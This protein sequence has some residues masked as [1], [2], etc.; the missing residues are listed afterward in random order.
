MHL[1]RT[2]TLDTDTLL[3]LTLVTAS[4]TISSFVHVHEICNQTWAVIW[5]SSGVAAANR[6]SYRYSV[7]DS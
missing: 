6:Y 5:K 1:R 3:Y 4:A 2:D 7:A